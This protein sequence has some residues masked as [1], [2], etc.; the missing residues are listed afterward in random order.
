VNI[1]CGSCEAIL[2]EDL[3]M[4]RIAAKFALRLLS[5]DHKSRSFQVCEELKRKVEM[6]PHFMS[7]FIAGDGTGDYR[8]DPE[9]GH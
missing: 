1:S 6:G 8:Y 9:T 4:R 2:T 3:A 7:R 5:D